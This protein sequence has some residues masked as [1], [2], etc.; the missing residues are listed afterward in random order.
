MDDTLPQTLR[1]WMLCFLGIVSI[2]V[3]ICM[4]TPVFAVIIVPL[5]IIYVLV[6]VGL[7]PARSSFSVAESPRFFLRFLTFISC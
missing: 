2:L 5:A 1:T 7:E 3:M 6:Q 4:A